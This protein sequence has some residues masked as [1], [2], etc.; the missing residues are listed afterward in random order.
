MLSYLTVCVLPVGGSTIFNN[1]M[2]FNIVLL[3]RWVGV[4]NSSAYSTLGYNYGTINKYS[5]QH[6][7]GVTHKYI[8]ALF[9]LQ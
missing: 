2:L 9:I 7:V 8:S 5:V 1:L 3:V 6:T 4:P